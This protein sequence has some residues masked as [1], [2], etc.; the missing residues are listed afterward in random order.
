MA[1]KVS[2]RKHDEG[3]GRA[4]IA[5]EARNGMPVGGWTARKLTR[6]IGLSVGSRAALGSVA[7]ALFVR[8]HGSTYPRR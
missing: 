2:V 5:A 6:G 7:A 8:Q 3:I 4:V 1:H